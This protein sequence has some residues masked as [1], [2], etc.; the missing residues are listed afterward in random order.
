MVYK[1]VSGSVRECLGGVWWSAWG[2]LVWEGCEG[3]LGDVR[4]GCGWCL[5]GVW[6]VSG[7]QS[8]R[9]LGVV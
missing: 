3:C 6:C 4:E 5:E 7:G 8:R 9:G 1:G 2:A